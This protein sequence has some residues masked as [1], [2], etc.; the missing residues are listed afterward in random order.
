MTHEAL[1]AR[2]AH[3]RTWKRDGFEVPHKTLVL[4]LALAKV[5]RGIRWLSF[6]TIDEPLKRLIEQFGEERHFYFPEEPFWR[7]KN[8][9]P[10]FWDIRNVHAGILQD[11]D[12]PGELELCE[13]DAQAGFT[14]DVYDALYRNPQWVLDVAQAIYSAHPVGGSREDVFRAVGLKAG[15]VLPARAESTC[16]LAERR[17]AAAAEPV[18]ARAVL[19]RG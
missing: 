13:W 14:D 15:V 9:K 18:S 6:R 5:Q 8:D 10:H 17:P 4:L 12:P 3:I 7:L 11:I 19:Q 2:F 16:A 1:L